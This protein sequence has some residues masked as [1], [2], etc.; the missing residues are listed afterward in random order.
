M[1]TESY[2]GHQNDLL[3]PTRVTGT[4]CYCVSGSPPPVPTEHECRDN[5]LGLPNHVSRGARLIRFDPG[6]GTGRGLPVRR[7][8]LP[9]DAVT[10]LT[11]RSGEPLPEH[12]IWGLSEGTGELRETCQ[13]VFEHE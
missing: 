4:G 11:H 7:F 2:S 3:L 13:G 1:L 12:S 6:G 10:M 8:A 9:Y 5:L